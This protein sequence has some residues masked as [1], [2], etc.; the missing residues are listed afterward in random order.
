LTRAY[1]K[2][3]WCQVVNDEEL[4]LFVVLASYFFNYFYLFVCS[5]Y[6]TKM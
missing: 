1:S 5:F 2:D 6:F 4:V 3:G